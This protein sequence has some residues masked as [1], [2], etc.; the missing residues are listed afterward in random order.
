MN[1]ILSLALLFSLAA[2]FSVEPVFSQSAS[3]MQQLQSLGFDN[4]QDVNVDEL[5]DDEVMRFYRQAQAQGLT[6]QEIG[7]FARARGLSASEVAKLR[8]RIN[9][10]QTTT[11][12]D[13]S[14]A[15]S[16]YRS[17]DP[18]SLL[19]VDSMESDTTQDNK[20]YINGVP[21][22]GSELFSS[23][24]R[25]FEPSLNIPTPVGYTLGVDDEIIINIWGAAEADYNLIIDPEGNIRVPNL[26]PIRVSGLS[27]EDARERILNRLTNIYSGL[28]LSNPEQGNTFA[29]VSLGNIRSINVSI[30]GEI[31]QPGSYTVSS[32]ASVFNLL[33]A[34]G[35][36]NQTGSWRS[37]EVIRGD[38][39]VE[40][41][42]LYDL[43][44]HGNPIGN[45]RLKDQDVIKVNPYQNRVRLLG[46]VKRPGIF[47]LKD[48]ESL[49]DLVEFTGGF[50][51]E[52]YKDRIVLKRIT[53]IQRSISDVKWPDGGDIL[54][55]NGDEIN[56]TNIVDRFENRVAISGA[57]YKPGDYELSENMTLLELIEKA[58]G[59]K[60]D[61]YMDRGI[62]L[63]S[64]D[65]LILESIPFSLSGL[66][67]GTEEDIVLRRDDEVRISSLFEMREEFRVRVNGAVNQTGEIE[68]LEDMTLEDAIYL[69]KGLRDEAAAYRVEVARRVV[70]QDT[71]TKV[72]QIAEVFQF[73]IDENFRFK[74][75]DSEF[76]LQP[77][78]QIFVRAKPNYQRQM[79]VRIEGEVQFPGEYVLEQRDARLTDLIEQA[80]GLSDFAYA[81]GASMQRILDIV[82][83]EEDSGGDLMQRANLNLLNLDNVEVERSEAVNDTII[84]PV[85]IRLADALENPNG[86]DDIRL[87]EGDVIRVPREFQT[88]R[89][90][91]GVLSPVSMRY[92]PG[93]GVQGYISAAGGTTDRGQRHRAYIVYANGE[94]DRTKR[95]LFIR[96]NPSVEPGAT[97]IV[98]EK[99][100]SEQ[101]SPQE[102]LAI[103][104]SLG[105]TVVLFL[106]ILDRL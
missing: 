101:M 32:L 29:D 33:Y 31:K 68:Y 52:A 76:E 58:E 42:D 67:D 95:F 9:R 97:I 64:R 16:G 46:E 6:V 89:V 38:E 22:F 51:E 79:T 57:V 105:T 2:L 8:S 40:T 102:R 86:R 88:I 34:A 78:D 54:L 96:S 63:R 39:I 41:F 103:A 98:P 61:V 20:M 14:D 82:V 50:S 87:Q 80:G 17:A 4:I 66:M 106:N 69:A 93:R 1:R 44:V 72:N 75:D 70:D 26:G 83:T 10:I 53:N 27:I 92:V 24:S 28:N 21:I 81:K 55:R 65:N 30:I 94:V 5:S 48:G 47:E 12:N 15:A 35:G 7:D 85:G 60:D 13:G 3:Q 100:A 49:A 77:F 104:T 25:S 19:Y 99:P 74:G 56:I 73:E 62:I 23:V 45:I 37:I 11:R 43:L 36:P 90:E 91:G 18:T 84:T 59:L 71:R